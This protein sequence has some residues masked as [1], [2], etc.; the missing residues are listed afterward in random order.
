MKSTTL[1]RLFILFFLIF[2]SKFSFSQNHYSSGDV[3]VQ[4][5]YIHTSDT[6]NCVINSEM[7][8]NIT[9][10]NANRNDTFKL[11]VPGI[12]GYNIGK[13]INLTGANPW[14]FKINSNDL[15]TSQCSNS[16]NMTFN[17][18]KTYKT[19]LTH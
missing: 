9:V 19:I 14:N 18:W 15:K 5:S 4:L 16:S 6:I 11:N 10:N 13:V 3:D 2:F 7:T 12:N 1:P 8:F 17:Y